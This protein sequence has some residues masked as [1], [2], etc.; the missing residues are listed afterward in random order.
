MVKEVNEIRGYVVIIANKLMSPHND[1]L[2]I[3]GKQ[4]VLH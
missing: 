2:V 1:R 4:A 3:S